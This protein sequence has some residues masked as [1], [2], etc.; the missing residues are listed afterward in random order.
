[1][2]LFHQFNCVGMD[3]EIAAEQSDF[4]TGLPLA[5][6]GA[7]NLKYKSKP[8]PDAKQLRKLIHGLFILGNEAA[9][10]SIQSFKMDSLHY[11][12]NLQLVSL[13]NYVKTYQRLTQ[14]MHVLDFFT[15]TGIC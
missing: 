12:S 5:I 8:S 6:V 14:Q 2:R 1:M 10:V 7:L 13:K 11:K 9:M 4:Y 3:V 15:W